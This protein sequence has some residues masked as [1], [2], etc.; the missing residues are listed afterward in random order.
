MFTTR[1]RARERVYR[2]EV[3]GVKIIALRALPLSTIRGHPHRAFSRR[4]VTLVAVIKPREYTQMPA[5]GRLQN[6]ILPSSPFNIFT[7][8][9]FFI[10]LTPPSLTH[11]LHFH[12]HCPRIFFSQIKIKFDTPPLRTLIMAISLRSIREGGRIPSVEPWPTDI[13]TI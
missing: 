5:K 13:R 12:F 6:R 4:K 2:C 1:A 3:H 8:S 9:I 11:P 7:R 10:N